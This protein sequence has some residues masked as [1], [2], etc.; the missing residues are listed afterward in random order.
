MIN[1]NSIETSFLGATLKDVGGARLDLTFAGRE[2]SRTIASSRL[3]PKSMRCVVLLFDPSLCAKHR[4]RASWILRKFF[5][6][7]GGRSHARQYAEGPGT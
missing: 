2:D 5:D 6:A 1:V 3:K 7:S 4:T